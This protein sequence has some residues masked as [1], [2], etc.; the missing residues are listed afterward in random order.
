[1]G[2]KIRVARSKQ[3]V[4]VPIVKE[5]AV[6]GSESGDNA[7][8]LS[9][10]SEQVIAD[11]NDKKWAY[12]EWN[13]C[14]FFTSCFLGMSSLSIMSCWFENDVASYGVCQF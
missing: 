7:R 3:F 5:P 1:M 10:T 13:I 12:G 11:D 4:K 6:E 9:S 14:I 8:E 2:R